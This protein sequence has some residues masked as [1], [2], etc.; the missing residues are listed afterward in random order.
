MEEPI[1]FVDL[2]RRFTK[3]A[4][5]KLVTYKVIKA[6][7]YSVNKVTGTMQEHKNAQ[8]FFENGRGTYC[9][10]SLPVISAYFSVKYEDRNK[11]KLVDI[12]WGS[13][14]VGNYELFLHKK[15]AAQHSIDILQAKRKKLDKRLENL[16]DIVYGINN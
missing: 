11:A 8:M 2:R 7:V 16:Y 13:F 3:K 9:S 1:S 10:I 5:D 12:V 15:E 6:T 14:Y 4:D